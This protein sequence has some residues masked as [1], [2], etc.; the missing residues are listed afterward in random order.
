MDVAK[1]RHEDFKDRIGEMFDVVLA[2]G[3]AVTLELIEARQPPEDRPDKAHFVEWKG[4]LDRPLD[5]RIYE[6]QHPELGTLPLFLVPVNQV[7]DGFVY[8]AVF[9][10]VED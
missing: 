7:A 10:R 5:Q 9:T 3:P 1:L 4:P 8:E 6:L 2:E